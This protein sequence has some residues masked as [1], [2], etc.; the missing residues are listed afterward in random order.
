MR[1][2]FLKCICEVLNTYEPGNSTLAL[3]FVLKKDEEEK[4]EAGSAAAA[5]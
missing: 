4:R 1:L 3:I 2:N 5:S